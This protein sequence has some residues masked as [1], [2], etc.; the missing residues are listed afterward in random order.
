VVEIIISQVEAGKKVHRYI[1]QLLPGVPLS[2]IHKMIRTGRIKHDG[3]KAKA[4]SIIKVGDV[5][6]IFMDDDDFAV[7]KK[8]DKKFLG[9]S[10]V[11][12]ILYSDERLI[13]VNKPAGLL[14]HG[15]EDEHKETLVNRVLA[16]LHNA[17]ELEKGVFTPSP[18]NRLDRNTSGI[19]V[20]ARDTKTAR[21]LSGVLLRKFYVAIVRGQVPL[22]GTIEAAL[23]RVGNRTVV[24]SQGKEAITKFKCLASSKSS[25]LVQIELVTGRTHQIRT[26]FDHIGHPLFGD[27]K[28]GG[29]MSRVDNES[30]HQWLHAGWLL[31]PDVPMLTAPLSQP[32]VNQLTRLDYTEEDI[33]QIQNLSDV[34]DI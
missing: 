22:E 4:D 33:R 20:F 24:V 11:I 12:D 18:I 13:V 8:A 15:A 34:W 1:R 14:T 23:E 30:Q 5:I 32:F 27:V 31:I 10:R 9:V 26:H 25:S 6:K 3:R 28:Y 19:V 7:V 2:G 29:R 21:D 17:G 16:Y